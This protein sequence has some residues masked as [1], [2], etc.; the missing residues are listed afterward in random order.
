MQWYCGAVAENQFGDLTFIQQLMKVKLPVLSQLY[1]VY[2]SCRAPSSPP[3]LWETSFL[4]GSELSRRFYPSY[5]QDRP[6]VTCSA[7]SLFT[8]SSPKRFYAGKKGFHRF[9]HILVSHVRKDKAFAGAVGQAL[10]HSLR[11]QCQP[12]AA[13]KTCL[14]SLD[15]TNFSES[16]ETWNCSGNS[17]FLLQWN[18][19]RL[20]LATMRYAN[21]HSGAEFIF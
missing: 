10:R 1:T 11:E 9:Q 2:F 13:H 4:C 20:I 12:R 18:W 17:D 15:A 14:C 6:F 16:Q 21:H 3:L 7:F 8:N 19:G 5:T